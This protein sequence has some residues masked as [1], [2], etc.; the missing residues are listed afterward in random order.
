VGRIVDARANKLIVRLAESQ[1]EI[2]ASLSLL[3]RVL[4]E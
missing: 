1:A 4:Y 2:D 3:Y